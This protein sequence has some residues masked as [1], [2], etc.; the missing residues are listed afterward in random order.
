MKVLFPTP[1]TPM[2]AMTR[3]LDLYDID[4][5]LLSLIRTHTVTLT[6]TWACSSVLT[7]LQRTVLQK[8]RQNHIHLLMEYTWVEL[9]MHRIDHRLLREVEDIVLKPFCSVNLKFSCLENTRIW[10]V[11]DQDSIQISKLIAR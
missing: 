2:T 11:V 5:L 4:W 9:R 7:V 6:S 10:A 8:S 1:V 3:S